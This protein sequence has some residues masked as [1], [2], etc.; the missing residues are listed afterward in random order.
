MK[1]NPIFFFFFFFCLTLNALCAQND[2]LPP[3]L[4]EL[5]HELSELKSPSPPDKTFEMFDIEKAPSFP[6]GEPALM[7]FLA[8]QIQYPALA[9][10]NVIQG[11]VAP[12]LLFVD[13]DGSITDIRIP[14]PKTLAQAVA[15]KPCGCFNP[16]PSGHRE[17]PMVNP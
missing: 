12:S 15:K 8:E 4:K 2:T 5:P 16:C 1:N 6:G 13:K 7:R 3:T 10:E 11:T 17:K 14:P 9:R